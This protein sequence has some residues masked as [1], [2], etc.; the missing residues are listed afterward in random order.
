MIS[1]TWRHVQPGAIVV[2]NGTHWVIDARTVATITMHRNEEP[3]AGLLTGTPDMDA[4]VAVLEPWAG[5]DPATEDEATATVKTVL[6]GI[7]T[8]A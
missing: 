4:T 5:Q 2:I 3:I 6:G 1:T 8:H 7:E